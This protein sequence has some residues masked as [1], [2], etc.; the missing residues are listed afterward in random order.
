MQK[1]AL[2]LKGLNVSVY[3]RSVE[4]Q[5][6]LSNISFKLEPGEIKALIGPS[7]SGK[8]VL[9][10]ALLGLLRAPVRI[11]TGKIF[12]FN[13]EIDY[14]RKDAFQAVRG[15]MI[16]TV[17][18]DPFSALNPVMKIGRQL[19][20]VI[21]HHNDCSGQ[22]ADERAVQAL[23]DV[24][25]NEPRRILA[26]YPHQL[27]GGQAQR[28]Q[29]ALAL[30]CRPRIL[31]ADEPTT[32]LDLVTQD[33][34]LGLLKRLQQEHR[35]AMILISHDLQV[36]SSLADSVLIL[37]NGKIVTDCPADALDSTPYKNLVQ[38]DLPLY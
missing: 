31:I 38:A 11:A 7:G 1:P 19:R 12:I 29:I 18:Q 25:L 17:F 30:S 2:M 26:S 37:H 36:V 8:T 4:V 28:V 21:C 33:K 9:G 35:F 3:N 15:R 34:I 32:A 10:L 6:V 27:S 24:G 5:P 16:S 14:R 23:E 13:E 20:D 22:Q